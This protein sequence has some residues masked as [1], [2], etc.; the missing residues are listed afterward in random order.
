MILAIDVGNTNIVLGLIENGEILD[1]TIRTRT[2]RD[3]TWAEYAIKLKDFFDFLEID[4]KTVEK[5]IISS[6]VPGVTDNIINAVEHLTKKECIKVEYNMDSG[7]SIKI[8]DPSTLGADLLVG[9]V[10][11]VEYYGAPCIMI[12]L[13]TGTT[14]T[15]VDKTGAFI[16]GAI[17]PGVALSYNALSSGT[18]LLPSISIT[19][20][21]M[22]IGKN[23]VDCMRS[24]AV[25]GT[26]SLVD[27]MIDRFKE[28]MGECAVVATGGLANAIV[29]ECRNK[30]IIDDEL[31]LKG[32][33]VLYKRNA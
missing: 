24:G 3:A 2:E 25:Y 17:I 21:G 9:A 31:L 14:I 6:V 11:A 32:L 18:S 10:G 13:G 19:A 27:G 33:W 20:P 15:A 1:N 8:D 30:I 23:T 28:E 4:P 12:D 7:I 26:A 29:K 16:G 22:C 5:S